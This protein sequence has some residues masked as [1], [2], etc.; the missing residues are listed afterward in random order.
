MDGIHRA[1]DRCIS[2]TNKIPQM[3]SMENCDLTFYLMHSW[4]HVGKHLSKFVFWY[5][6]K[7]LY[8]RCCG[9]L[10]HSLAS[11][12]ESRNDSQYIYFIRSS[13]KWNMK[14]LSN[15]SDL[16]G[17]VSSGG[18]LPIDERINLFAISFVQCANVYAIRMPGVN[19]LF[20]LCSEHFRW[21][22]C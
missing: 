10:L 17:L 12:L 1:F 7:H 16:L 8:H 14:F 11:I 21:M 13:N 2:C 19:F 22:S 18:C 20:V 9:R 6:H 5:L 4:I 3:K 15:G